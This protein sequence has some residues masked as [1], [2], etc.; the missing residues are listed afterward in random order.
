MQLFAN[1][2]L[3]SQQ[4]THKP[5]MQMHNRRRIKSFMD[6]DKTQPNQEI[7]EA[8]LSSSADVTQANA[9]VNDDES[10]DT[11]ET[12]QNGTA[13]AEAVETT[14]PEDEEV[15]DEQRVEEGNSVL[16]KLRAEAEKNLAGWQRERAEFQNFKRRIEREQRD[17]KEKSTL[18][19]ISQLLPIID[20]FERA[21]ENVPEEFASNP[22]LNGVSLIQGKF[23]K[24]LD[25]HSV[26]TIDPVGEP[27]D[28]NHHQAIS[29]DDSDEYESDVVIQTLQKGY[30]SGDT[31]LR[32]ALVRVAN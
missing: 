25:A 20:D 31:L 12:S 11:Q 16:N 29:K 32:P 5:M 15:I 1:A 10:Q 14:A 17:M 23:Q 6:N 13:P 22:W 26:E 19:A 4:Y 27:F 24:L 3:W 9:A 2:I 30:I 21:L 28:P 8:D 18:E 7:P